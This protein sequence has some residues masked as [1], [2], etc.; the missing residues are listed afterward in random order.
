MSELFIELFS[1][2]IPSA[3]QS[4]ARSKIKEF[5][6]NTAKELKGAIEI[7]EFIRFKVGEAI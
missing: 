4:D 1:D 7:K 6:E 3:L 5:I 2:E